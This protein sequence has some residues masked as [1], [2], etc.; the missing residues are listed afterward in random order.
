MLP[1]QAQVIAC[2]MEGKSR[3]YTGASLRFFLLLTITSP[4]GK[5]NSEKLVPHTQTRSHWE[6]MKAWVFDK[7]TDIERVDHS[8]TAPRPYINNKQD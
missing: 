1:C 3:Q 7:N 2:Q 4:L 8:D 6:E 5:A